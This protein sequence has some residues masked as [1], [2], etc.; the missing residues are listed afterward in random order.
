M[1]RGPRVSVLIGAWN[2]AATLRQAAESILDQ[3]L[4]ELELLLIDDGSTDA[5]PDVIGALAGEDPRVRPLP[6]SHMGI[7]GSLN[8]GLRVARAPIVAV[9]DA[10]DWSAPDRLARQ[11]ALLERRPDLALVGCRMREVNEDG[12]ELRPRTAFAVGDVRA[13]LLRFNPIPNSCATFRRGVA[14]GLGSYDTRYRY[15]MEYDLWLRMTDCHGA[16]TLDA[17]LATRRM[18]GANVA[19]RAERAQIAEALAIRARTLRR[20]RSLRGASGLVLPAVSYVTPLPLKRA[21]RR[22]LG[23]AP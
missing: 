19:A 4:V 23:M 2:N 20:R 6:L 13:A 18:S 8:A 7:A 1:T 17:P 14:L 11:A 5:T 3:T 16:V 9:N 12:H 10:D 22:R 15:A 21:V